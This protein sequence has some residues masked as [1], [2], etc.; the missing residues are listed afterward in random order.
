MNTC[1]FESENTV[2]FIKYSSF[3]IIDFDTKNNNTDIQIVFVYPCTN[4]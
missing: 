1:I 3:E 2:T 4:I